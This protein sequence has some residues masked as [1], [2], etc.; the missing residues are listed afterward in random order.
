[1]SYGGHLIFHTQDAYGELRVMDDG[2]Q[3][4]LSF[5]PGDEQSACFKSD[6]ARPVFEYTQAMLLP[7]LFQTPKKAL[8]LG[9]GAGTLVTCLHKQFKGLKIQA[10]E[11]RQAVIDIAHQYFYL[12]H[13]KQ[14]Q[15]MCQDAEDYMSQN[16]QAY[17]L[18]F[19]DLYNFDGV[20]EM[21][22]QNAFLERCQKALK[23]TGWLVLNCWDAH[24]HEYNLLANLDTG[25]NEIWH[26][27]TGDGNWVVMARARPVTKDQ[28][29]LKQAAKLWSQRL[30]CSMIKHFRNLKKYD[31]P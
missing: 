10:V 24:Q 16:N 9:L 11:L 8:C 15:I 1:M 27:E 30:Q 25:S 23:P 22:M 26:C 28:Q 14:I 20:D 13:S 17:D 21:Q 31:T 6:P 5:G 12:P 19:C 3:H 4:L 7:L 29:E 18:I 2:T